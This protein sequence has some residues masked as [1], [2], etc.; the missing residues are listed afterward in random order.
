MYVA[1]TG[2]PATLSGWKPV[3]DVTDAAARQRVRLDTAGNRFR[4]YLIWIEKLPPGGQRWSCRRS[5]VRVTSLVVALA[6]M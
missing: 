5:S 6:A 4:Y 2:P 3:G 1:E